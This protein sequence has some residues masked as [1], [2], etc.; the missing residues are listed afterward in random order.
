VWHSAFEDMR[1]YRRFRRH[2]LL[3]AREYWPAVCRVS[4]LLRLGFNT[5]YIYRCDKRAWMRFSILRAFTA[6][7]C[8]ASPQ[9]G[10]SRNPHP[11]SF[12]IAFGIGYIALCHPSASQ[13]A[14]QRMSIPQ[15]EALP[16]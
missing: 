9:P 6:G 12:E 11:P 7:V 8:A 3:R 16:A 14:M 10:A 13:N 5:R 2:R 1:K 4:F 15:T